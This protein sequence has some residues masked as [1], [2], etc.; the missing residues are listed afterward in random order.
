MVGRRVHATGP[1]RLKLGAK[2][3][4]A[5]GAGPWSAPS[6]TAAG[7][8]TGS[9]TA[10]SPRSASPCAAAAAGHSRRPARWRPDCQRQRPRARRPLRVQGMPDGL[11]GALVRAMMPPAGGELPAAQLQGVDGVLATALTAQEVA[12][13]SRGRGRAAWRTPC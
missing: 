10:C 7:A 2:L 11:Y 5:C 1:A 13:G 9:S 4:K 8:R 3:K 12:G 6:R